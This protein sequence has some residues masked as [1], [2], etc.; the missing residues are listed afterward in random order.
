MRKDTTGDLRRLIE[1][2][3]QDATRFATALEAIADEEEQLASVSADEYAGTAEPHSYDRRRHDVATAKAKAAEGKQRADLA[4]RGL[5]SRALAAVEEQGRARQATLSDSISAGEAKPYQLRAEQ[6][7]VERQLATDRDQLAVAE[8]ETEDNSSEFLALLDEE[9]AQRAAARK[10]QREEQAA[11]HARNN[12]GEPGACLLASAAR[13]A[14][15]SSAGRRSPRTSASSCAKRA[16][17]RW[18]RSA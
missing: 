4:I 12:P 8:Q 5:A 7:R 17:S 9:A 3:Q 14:R 13:S 15:R 11:W 2:A 6:A 10:R 18:Q 16:S 1:Q